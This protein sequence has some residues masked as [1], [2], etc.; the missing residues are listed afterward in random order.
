M[1]S[2]DGSSSSSPS[3]Q[4]SGNPWSLAHSSGVSRRTTYP[5][6]ATTGGS[7][8]SVATRDGAMSLLTRVKWSA[9][10][11][12]H[13]LGWKSVCSLPLVDSVA[14]MSSCTSAPRP[15][16]P[17][18]PMRTFIVTGISTIGWLPPPVP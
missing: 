4:S 8:E 13:T 18:V 5:D 9:L 12:T 16:E 6:L 1:S 11:A 15:P 2:S 17:D 7:F 14:A 10:P 3:H